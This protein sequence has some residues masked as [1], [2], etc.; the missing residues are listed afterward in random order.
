[1]KET[2]FT[3]ERNLKKIRDIIEKMQMGDLDFDEN[4]ALFKEGSET[5]A[6][7]KKYLDQSELLIKK[8]VEG[9]EID[10]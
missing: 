5:I 1:M 4:V 8:L 7:C 3:L 9:E 2:P 6:A 10:L